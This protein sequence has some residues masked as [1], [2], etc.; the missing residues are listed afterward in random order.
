MNEKTPVQ[1]ALRWLLQQEQVIAIPKSGEPA[2]I[3]DN[4][5]VFDFELSQGEMDRIFALDRDERLIN[6]EFAPDWNES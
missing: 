6:P 1:V 2:H 3:R 5:K 4:I